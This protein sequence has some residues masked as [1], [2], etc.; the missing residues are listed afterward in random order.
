MTKHIT[1]HQ[2]HTNNYTDKE[3]CNL[4]NQRV[5]TTNDQY[6]ITHQKLILLNIVTDNNNYGNYT[7]TLCVNWEIEKTHEKPS[8]KLEFNIDK[9]ET[10]LKE[11]DFN[12]TTTNNEINDMNNHKMGHLSNNLTSNTNHQNIQ[13]EQNNHNSLYTLANYELQLNSDL[14]NPNGTND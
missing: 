5:K 7:Y 2:E 6:Y 14:E 11:I 4:I 3:M 13:Q 10:G 9:P 12:I 8:K 1:D